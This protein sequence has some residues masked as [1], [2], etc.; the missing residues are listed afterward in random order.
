MDTLQQRFGRGARSFGREA[1]AILIAEPTF[2]DDDGSAQ[3]AAN[4]KRTKRKRKKPAMN[5]D[6]PPT[7]KH[8]QT[9]QIVPGASTD[10]GSSL[11]LHIPLTT[12]PVMMASSGEGKL[13]GEQHHTSSDAQEPSTD[14]GKVVGGVGISVDDLGESELATVAAS[15]VLPMST[16]TS[17]RKCRKKKLGD[18][19]P[20]DDLVNVLF[21]WLQVLSRADAEVLRTERGEIR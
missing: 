20:M 2:F 11:G 3:D 18:D 1:F 21:P 7:D 10:A 19:I 6:I 17:N 13:D 15:A 12:A 9:T 8:R 4:E 16:I 14:S 5:L